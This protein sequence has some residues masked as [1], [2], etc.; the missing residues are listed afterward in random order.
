MKRLITAL[1]VGVLLQTLLGQAA[2]PFFTGFISDRL[3]LASTLAVIPVMSLLAA[4]A[5]LLTWRWYDADLIKAKHR[6]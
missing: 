6:E 2:G 5:F 3:G 4:V 1:A